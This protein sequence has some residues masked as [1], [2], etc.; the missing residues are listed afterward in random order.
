[1][2]QY[3][4]MLH[5]NAQEVDEKLPK[6]QPPPEGT[7]TC[8]KY[9]WT[10]DEHIL[11]PLLIYKY[12]WTNVKRDEEFYE[13]FEK[14]AEDLQDLHE[15]NEKS[16]H[17]GR[18][19]SGSYRSDNYTPNKKEGDLANFVKD[20]QRQYSNKRNRDEAD[21]ETKPKFLPSFGQE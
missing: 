21:V 13:K 17:S 7:G 15:M 18:S 3:D 8:A 9:L 12:S 11:R 2:S 16:Y 19:R 5:P 10:F 6:Y 1:M 4:E 14:N 20:Q